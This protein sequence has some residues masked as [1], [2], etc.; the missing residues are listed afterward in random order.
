MNNRV[1]SGLKVSTAS[2]PGL[3]I[4][5]LVASVTNLTGRRC[6]AAMVYNYERVGLISIPQR[7]RGGFRLFR[8]ED[9]AQVIHIKRW[10]EEG[11]SLIEIKSRMK[12]GEELAE[13]LSLIN[14]PVDRRTQILEVAARIFPQKGF[15]ETTIQDIARE[16]DVSS[17]AIYQYFDSKEDLFLALTER[18]SFEDILE[19]INAVLKRKKTLEKDDISQA[20]ISVANA[21][22]DSHRPNAE[23]MRMFASEAKR[24]PEVGMR[25]C[26]R[27]IIPVE[28]LLEKYFEQ[29]VQRGEFRKVN[30]KLAVHAF[31]GIFLNFI[32]TQD[33]LYGKEQMHFPPLDEAVPQL[34]DLFLKGILEPRAG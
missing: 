10:Q 23:I 11:L 13:T 29:Q 9:V 17:S 15:K 7:T 34:V 25:Y 5:E 14:L 4:G 30:L 27:L 21:Y 31:Y 26:E 18:I 1:E 6:T 16:A 22:L 19:E 32:V 24:Y 20:L 3:T 12:G 8:L 2:E 33:L 28:E